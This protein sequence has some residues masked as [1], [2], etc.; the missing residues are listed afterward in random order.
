MKDVY[1]SP[2]ATMR[3]LDLEMF[4]ASSWHDG[5]SGNSSLLVNQSDDITDFQ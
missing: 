3:S 5:K 2:D 4:L 1:V